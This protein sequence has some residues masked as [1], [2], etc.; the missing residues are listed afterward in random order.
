LRAELTNLTSEPETEA[1]K[2]PGERAGEAE[3][4]K[5]EGIKR[6]GGG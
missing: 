4:L 5:I 2:R 3:E 6:A 1:I